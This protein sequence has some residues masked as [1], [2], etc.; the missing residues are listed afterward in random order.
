[1]H[2]PPPPR[3]GGRASA[4]SSPVPAASPPGSRA[5]R[6][7]IHEQNAIAGLL[8]P[9]CSR[10]SRA[11]VLAAFPRRLS[12]RRRRARGRQPGARRRSRSSRRRRQRFARREGALRLLVVGGSLGAARAQRRGAV[13]DRNWPGLAALRCATRR[14]SAAS[15]RRAR[16]TREAGV[17][18]RRRAV[19]RRHGAGL[20]R[21]GPGDLPRRRARRSPSWPRWAS[22]AILV[23]FPAAVDDH[24]TRQRAVP[25]ARGRRGADR[26]SRPHAAAARGRARELLATGAADCSPWRSARALRGAAAAPPSSSRA[27]CCLQARMEAA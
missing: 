13:R 16:P 4:A 2:A 6:C 23:P 5:G 18:G 11:R 22:A 12:G 15:R 21:G 14:A 17:A 7:V 1:M 26:G 24:Q 20:R 27:A 19:H 3:A 8:E 25:G 9:L 10:A